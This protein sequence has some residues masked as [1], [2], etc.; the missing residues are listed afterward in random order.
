MSRRT[1]ALAVGRARDAGMAAAMRGAAYATNPH[2][3]DPDLKLAWRN[4]HN[5]MRARLAMDAETR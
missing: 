1:S 5:G 3:A 4:G 2:V